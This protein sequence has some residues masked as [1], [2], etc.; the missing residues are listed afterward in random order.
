M[1]SLVVTAKHVTSG[2]RHKWLP[3]M[4]QSLQ[5]VH[6]FKH[7]FNKELFGILNQGIK[8]Y[9]HVKISLMMS[10]KHLLLRLFFFGLF[11]HQNLEYLLHNCLF[12]NFEWSIVLEINRTKENTRYLGYRVSHPFLA[13]QMCL[14]QL[15]EETW[16]LQIA[17]L[18]QA[19]YQNSNSWRILQ[20]RSLWARTLLVV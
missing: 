1:C 15:C 2:T 7:L 10:H 18:L 5:A 4:S 13:N 16:F 12:L 8:E 17:H 19:L 3:E 14:H 9:S 20:Q 6:S 11:F